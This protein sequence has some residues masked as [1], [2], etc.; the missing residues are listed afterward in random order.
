MTTWYNVCFITARRINWTKT[1]VC[2]SETLGLRLAVSVCVH[3]CAYAC[4]QCACFFGLRPAVA[5]ARQLKNVMTLLSHCGNCWACVGSFTLHRQASNFSTKKITPAVAWQHSAVHGGPHIPPEDGQL[6]EQLGCPLAMGSQLAQSNPCA[7]AGCTVSTQPLAK[8]FIELLWLNAQVELEVG[9][10]GWGGA[11]GK[12]VIC[13]HAFPTSLIKSKDKPQTLTQGTK[14]S[15][16]PPPPV[17]TG[18][19]KIQSYTTCVSLPHSPTWSQD[20]VLELLQ[21]PS[22]RVPCME[23]FPL[24][25]LSWG[26]TFRTSLLLSFGL[27]EPCGWL[28]THLGSLGCPHRGFLFYLH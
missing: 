28:H 5:Q 26:P 20:L 13:S 15:P 14:I 3:T 25:P 6:V 18:K 22:N 24:H 1:P 27:Q 19:Q 4:A 10:R 7:W 2:V 8:A 21:R 11:S 12:K 17:R 23:V 9:T 16:L